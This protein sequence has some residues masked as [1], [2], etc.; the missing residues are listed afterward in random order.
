MLFFASIDVTRSNL[1]FSFVFSVFKNFNT[2]SNCVRVCDPNLFMCL[3]S[4]IYESENKTCSNVAANVRERSITQYWYIIHL[5]A[6]LPARQ[7]ANW[8]MHAPHAVC[9]MYPYVWLYICWT[10]YWVHASLVSPIC[11]RSRRVA[12]WCFSLLR[13]LF[14][15]FLVW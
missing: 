4:I 10:E 8:H 9:L 1:I 15:F 12:H 7:S 3:L 6:K 11:K 13:L 2:A 14:F 5:P